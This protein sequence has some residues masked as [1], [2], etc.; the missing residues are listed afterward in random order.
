M[1]AHS[2]NA[3]ALA[4]FLEMR[5]EVEDVFYIGLPNHRHHEVAQ[6][7]L[8]DGFGGMFSMRLRGGAQAMNEFANSVRIGAIAVSLGDVRTLVYPMPKRDNLIRISVG[9]EDTDDLLADFE[10]A[11]ARVSVHAAV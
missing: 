10:Q 9:C 11:L 7:L 8:S 3:Q 4:A 1:A 2:R 6:R 5:E